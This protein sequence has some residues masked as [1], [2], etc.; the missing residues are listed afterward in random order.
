MELFQSSNSDIATIPKDT[1]DPL[2]GF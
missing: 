2:E 1:V